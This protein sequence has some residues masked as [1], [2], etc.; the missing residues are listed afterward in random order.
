MSEM[1]LTADELI[2][3]GRGQL[4]RQA[5]VAEIVS[6]GPA[7]TR[8]RAARIEELAALLRTAAS[9][10]DPRQRALRRRSVG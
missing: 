8:V 10:R 1:A 6:A 4:I 2:V 3:I 7:S 9:R 5:S